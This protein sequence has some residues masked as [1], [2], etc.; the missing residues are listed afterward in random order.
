M[1]DASGYRKK[2]NSEG[3]AGANQSWTWP[4]N[5]ILKVPIQI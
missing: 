4:G 2:G 1:E 3:D 5:D